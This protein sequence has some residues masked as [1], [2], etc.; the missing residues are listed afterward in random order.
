MA[1]HDDDDDDD[2]DDDIK[3]IPVMIYCINCFD[4]KFRLVMIYSGVF[5]LAKIFEWKC[6]SNLK[7]QTYARGNIWQFNTIFP[8]IGRPN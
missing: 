4:F 6:K 3:I 5:Y 7:G 2:D 8:G 1:R